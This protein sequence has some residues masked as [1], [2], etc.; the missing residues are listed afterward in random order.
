M[1]IVLT[2]L[3]E[4]ARSATGTVVIIDV[5]RA[6]T[7]AAVAFQQGA[8]KII[9]VGEIED[10]LKLKSQGVGEICVGEVGGKMPEGFDHG[11]SPY[12]LSSM[13]LMGKTLIQ[14]TRAGTVGVEAATQAEHI[15][16]GSLAVAQATAQVIL[17]ERPETVTLVA[18][19]WEGRDRTDEDEHCG[20]YMRNLLQGLQPDREA[21]RS[22]V[23][24]CKESQ[25]F[26]NPDKPHFHPGDRD[27]ALDID[28]VPFAIQITREGGLLIARPESP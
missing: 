24:G 1:N 8:E 3:L 9:L 4:G 21:V 12:E 16:G 20:L 7:T 27:R 17:R 22:L 28:S 14:S 13:D 23:L 2:S 10:A 11:N 5:Y 25:K 26:D 15:Y 19:G 18:M 6:F